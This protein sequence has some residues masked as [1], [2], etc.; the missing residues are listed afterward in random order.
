MTMDPRAT[1]WGKEAERAVRIAY[2]RLGWFVVPAY[3]I[4]DG[5]APMLARLIERHVLPDMLLAHRGV[6]RWL[7]C[8]FKD[9]CVK[10]NKT[11]FFRHGID[12]PKWQA[13]REVERITGIPGWLAILQFRPGAEADPDPHLLVQSLEHLAGILDVAAEPTATAP[14][15][16]VYWNVDEM[17]TVTRLDFGLDVERLTEV[18]HPWEM[19]TK[20]GRAPHADMNAQQRQFPFSDYDAA[21]DMEGSVR[22][23]YRAIKERVANGGP[24]FDENRKP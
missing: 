23:C 18:I 10:Y 7:E 4:E 2:E 13:Y 9:H 24:G 6:S 1:L 11:G 14:R 21:K 22:E 17:D 20:D 5:G 8:K 3:A 15:G 12:L 16:M 19:K